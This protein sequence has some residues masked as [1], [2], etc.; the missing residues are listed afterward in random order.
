MEIIVLH[1]C[2]IVTNLIVV[3][4]L[5]FTFINANNVIYYFALSFI[6]VLILLSSVAFFTLLERKVL[7]SSQNRK[8]PNKVGYFGFL[9]PVADGLKL[10]LKETIIPQNSILVVFFMSSVFSLF[11]GLLL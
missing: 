2:S 6:V 8:G 3:L 4:N 11:F 10:F 1:L 9:Q 5:K 7:A